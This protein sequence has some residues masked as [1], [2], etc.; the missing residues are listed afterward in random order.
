MKPRAQIGDNVFA[1]E[2]SEKPN[3][4]LRFL[5]HPVHNWAGLAIRVVV[6]SVFIYA[7][8]SKI[9]RP[10]DFAWSIAMYRMLDYRYV[11]LLA[12]VLPWA[13]LIC[14]VTLLSG[15]WTRGSAVV[16][17]GMTVMFIWALTHAITHQIEMTSCGCFSQA[18]A[19]ALSTH[20]ST[21]SKSLL[22][23]DIAML[24]AAGYVWLFDSGRIGVDGILKRWKNGTPEV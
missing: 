22:H 15:L 23:R 21:V 24:F 19:K 20:Q 18:G 4:V 12:V 7:A 11:H 17:C 3:P 9:A 13:E 1:P 2:R 14:G 8:I 6:G 5:D 16:V 10:M